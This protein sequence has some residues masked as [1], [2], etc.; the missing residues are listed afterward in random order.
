MNQLLLGQVRANHQPSLF[1]M[2]ASV[3]S[4][5]PNAN[6]LGSPPTGF[7]PC[8][9]SPVGAA[10]PGDYR[11]NLKFSCLIPLDFAVLFSDAVALTEGESRYL[12]G[13][14]SR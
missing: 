9:K 8:S 13:Q 2:A 10:S 11:R 12:Q 3:R 1:T 6:L 4:F 7:Q 5:I 14:D